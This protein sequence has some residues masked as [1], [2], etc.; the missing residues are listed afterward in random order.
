MSLVNPIINH[1]QRKRPTASAFTSNIQNMPTV[2]PVTGSLVPNAEPIKIQT[3]IS[4]AWNP[5]G[6][7]RGLYK[8]MTAPLSMMKL[9]WLSENQTFTINNEPYRAFVINEDMYLVRFM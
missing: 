7:I 6:S 1:R 4:G 5:G 9:Y 8:S 2:D 3:S